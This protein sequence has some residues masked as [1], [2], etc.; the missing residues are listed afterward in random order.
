[1]TTNLFLSAG[2]RSGPNFYNV[3]MTRATEFLF[4]TWARKRA[5]PTARQ[6]GGSS[7]WRNHS[8]FLDGGPVSSVDGADFLSTIPPPE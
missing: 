6:G 5:G 1:M 8:H 3:A 2:V 4:I 7:A